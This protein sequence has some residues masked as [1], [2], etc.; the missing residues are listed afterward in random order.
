MTVAIT[1]VNNNNKHLTFGKGAHFCLG[2][3]LARMELKVV[4]EHFLQRFSKIEAVE[5]F[6]LE[7]NLIDAATGQTLTYLPLKAFK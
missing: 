4:L 3:P 5:F 6:D 7:C 1:I 2:A